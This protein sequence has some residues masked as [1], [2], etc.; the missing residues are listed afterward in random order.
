MP[1]TCGTLYRLLFDAFDGRASLVGFGS[2]RGVDAD[3]FYYDSIIRHDRAKEK[4]PSSDLP[5]AGD[6]M[7]AVAAD[8]KGTE[9]TLVAVN[10]H[11]EPET[12]TVDV[13]GVRIGPATCRV[14]SCPQED[15]DHFETPGRSL[16]HVETKAVPAPASGPATFV[17]PPFSVLTARFPLTGRF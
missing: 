17:V 16:G 9:G 1:G 12:V 8:S 4:D 7:W 11:A 13:K 3:A 6:C 10:T 15:L 2:S 14:L 5:F